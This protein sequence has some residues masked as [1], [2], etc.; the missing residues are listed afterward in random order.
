M[1]SAAL[2]HTEW[3]TSS[4]PTTD[5]GPRF[6]HFC[7]S[8]FLHFC[9]SAF[10]HFCISAFLHFRMSAFLHFCIS[11]FLH[12]CISAFL[13]F[14]TSA[15]LHFCISAFPHFCISAFLHFCISAFL[16]FFWCLVLERETHV[17]VQR[18]KHGSG[19]VH[20]PRPDPWAQAAPPPHSIGAGCVFPGAP[21]CHHFPLMARSST[22]STCS[23]LNRLPPGKSHHP[24]LE[25]FLDYEAA[26][27]NNG[28]KQTE[29]RTMRR[30]HAWSATQ[31]R[32]HFCT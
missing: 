3:D 23:I 26:R 1:V 13:H 29:E 8:A 14:C 9:I 12:F 32:S 17:I 28:C 19:P 4:D 31:A 30:S 16:H 11:A 20:G 25:S 10:L 6:P 22:Q 24:C 27:G 21:I 15:F 7:I 5:P 2:N 18:Q